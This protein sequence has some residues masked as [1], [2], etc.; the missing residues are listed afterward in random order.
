M[1]RLVCALLLLLAAFAAQAADEVFEHPA[2]ATQLR[3]LLSAP[4]RELSS[5]QVL[6]GRFAQKK[7][8]RELPM[9]LPS[10]GDFL[11]ARELGIAW[12]T[13]TPFDSEF[14]LTR[15]G[16]VQKDGG[17]V[18]LKLS[19][20]QQPALQV[21]LRLF[22]AL[23]SLDLDAL[24]GDFEL[25]GSKAGEGWQL[26]LKPK[27]AAM[28]SA[29]EQA[30]IE[31]GKAVERIEMRDRNGDRTE[32]TILDLQGAATIADEDRNRFAR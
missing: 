9:A 19:A 11:F 7:F 15:D 30:I 13:R 18:A 8:L 6:H 12:H 22:M 2:G 16:M 5:T 27:N 20:D 32:I 26:G 21:A 10:D 1:S 4:A 3:A 29:F 14:L 23:F 17:K 25:Y 31:G 24:A 28:A